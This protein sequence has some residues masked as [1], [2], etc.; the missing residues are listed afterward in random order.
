MSIMDLFRP[1]WKSSSPDVRKKSLLKEK[2]LEVISEALNCETEQDIISVVLDQNASIESLEQIKSKTNNEIQQLI[3]KK[4]HKLYL[5]KALVA[6][7]PDSVSFDKLDSKQL[8]R[9]AREAKSQTVQFQTIDRISENEILSSII[10]NTEK[11]VALHALEKLSDK[12]TLKHLIK[13][14]RHKGTRLLV[15][16]RYDDLFGEE[17]KAQKRLEDGIQSLE[18]I[19]QALEEIAAL[20]EWNNSTKEFESLLSRWQE[21]SEFVNEEL[22]NR[23]KASCEKCL[24]TKAV[25]DAEQAAKDAA[26][27]VIDQRIEKRQALLKELLAAAEI[28]QEN[29]LE[30]VADFKAH[31]DAVGALECDSEKDLGTR[32]EKGVKSFDAKQEILQDLAN[33]ETQIKESLENILSSLNTLTTS[34]VSFDE[35]ERTLNQQLTS[36]SKIS[37]ME[38]AKFADTSKSIDEV[39]ESLKEKSIILKEAEEAR[40]KEV[41]ELYSKTIDEVAAFTETSKES[42]ER[43]KELQ[44]SWKK[45]PSLPSKEAEKLSS[46]F[47][48]ACDQYFDK[49]KD[50]VEE[51][52]W[53]EFANLSAKEKL[54]IDLQA[55]DASQDPQELAKKIK[56]YQTAWKEIGQVPHAKADEVWAKF[57]TITDKLYEPCKEYYQEKDIEREKSLVVKTGLVEKAEELT[58]SDNWKETA[59]QLKELQAQWKAAGPAPRKAEKELWERFRKACD[60]FFAKRKEYFAE[61]DSGRIEN[62]TKKEALLKEIGEVLQ[63]EKLREAGEKIK[64]LQKEWKEIGPAERNKEKELWSKFRKAADEFFAKRKENYQKQQ[65]SY[66][67]NAQ[68]KI[69]LCDKLEKTLSDLNDETDWNA[70]SQ[71]Y[72]QAQKDWNNLAGAGFEKDKELRNKLKDICSRF[73]KVRDEH[74]DKLSDEDRENLEKKEEFCLKVELLAESSEWRETADELKK[75][76][77]EYNALQSVNEKYDALMLKRFNNICKGF[78][79][80]RREHFEEMDD[81]RKD[82]LIKKEEL[83]K[84]LEELAGVEYAGADSSSGGSANVEDLAAQLQDAFSNNFG[85]FENTP[86]KPVSFREVGQEVRELQAAWKEIG[87][88]TNS[89]SQKVWERFR[90]AAD[91][92]YAKRNEF[93]A[94][95]EKDYVSNLA[96]KK[97]ILTDLKVEG[98]KEKADFRVVKGLQKKWREC[99]DVSRKDSRDIFTEFR[100]LCDKI[101]G[102]GKTEEENEKDNIRI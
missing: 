54:I 95:K 9:L 25:F 67:E 27:K 4:L 87:P 74:Y 2:D 76:Q 34:E 66:E 78:F 84:R 29:S 83:C 8:G 31:W 35:F 5:E 63:W 3:E 98:A 53:T 11:K 20:S 18:E 97:Q 90:K 93:Y 72:N 60:L 102:S 50:Y 77:T 37:K 58:S 13:A 64:Q 16:K 46:T 49:V 45:L 81:T 44:K 57:K 100:T 43:V 71:T 30:L 48:K 10:Q 89:K 19:L 6:E 32:F 24:Q 69:A 36:F 79:D 86:E 39:A 22:N 12:E 55:L 1:D 88:V 61:I 101:Y 92:F 40:L 52:E 23:Y 73:F 70:L 59:E 68:E 33:R 51:R 65:S 14:A 96:T 56:E 80:R 91:A 15:R 75:L 26:Q 42:T 21:N 99:G 17:E 41:R 94:E 82:N 7:S 47:R 85:G 28:L 38:K 62:T